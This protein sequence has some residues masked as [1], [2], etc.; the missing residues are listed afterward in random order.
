MKNYNGVLTPLISRTVLKDNEENEL[1]DDDNSA[2][3]DISYA[4]GQ[5]ARFMSKPKHPFLGHAKH[6]LRY[7]QRTSRHRISYSAFKNNF[8][9]EKTKINVFD[10]FAD[11]TWGTEDDRKSFHGYVVLDN[12]GS[13]SWVSQR[14]KS[15][16]LSSM[17]AEIIAVN[18]GAKEAAWMEKL[19]KDLHQE[20]FTPT[21]WND[22]IAK[23]RLKVDRI[24]GT[25][26]PADILTKQ[27]P[28]ESLVR[29]MDKMGVGISKI[30]QV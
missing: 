14:Q 13:I 23:N 5:L 11:A 25:D 22:M 24:A 19:W 6:L 4:V 15:T 21:L 8:S 17:E 26:N 1:L 9:K 16:A 27:L 29:Q 7:L 28:H 3:P 10:I 30:E 12:A 18:E 20:N 2:L